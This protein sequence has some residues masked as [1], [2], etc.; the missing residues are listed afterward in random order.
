VVFLLKLID[1]ANFGLLR[2][3]VMA[4]FKAL[5]IDVGRLPSRNDLHIK[6]MFF[7]ANLVIVK[8]SAKE[9]QD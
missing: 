4:L 5:A 8:K 6:W 7:A 1:E 2:S 3:A 9:S